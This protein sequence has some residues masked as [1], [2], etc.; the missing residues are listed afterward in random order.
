[1]HLPLLVVNCRMNRN[2]AST[3]CK[4]ACY[5]KQLDNKN[6]PVEAWNDALAFI[7]HEM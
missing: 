6:A 1:M 5:I 2:R 4:L 7:W 3:R